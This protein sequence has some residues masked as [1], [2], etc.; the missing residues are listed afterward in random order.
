MSHRDEER[1]TFIG[2]IERKRNWQD[3][4]PLDIVSSAS[5]LCCCREVERCRQY[6]SLS[7]ERVKYASRP[8]A[9]YHLERRSCIDCSQQK[10]FARFFCRI[11]K[12]ILQL[13]G[14]HRPDRR[15]GIKL[16]EQTP[17]Q[18]RLLYPTLRGFVLCS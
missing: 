4:L 15:E 12:N 17:R 1:E 3:M 11:T 14:T 9:L 2:Y 13:Y 10:L 5:P 16:F 8:V 7:R 18:T 6:Y